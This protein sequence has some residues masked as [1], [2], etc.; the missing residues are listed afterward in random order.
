MIKAWGHDEL[1]KDLAAHLKIPQRMVWTDMQLGPSGSV[2]PDVYVITKSYVRPHPTAYECKISREDFRAD[3][4]AGKWQAYLQ[5]AHAVIFA[6]P[7]GL[8]EKRE[9]PELCGLIVRYEKSWRAVRAATINPRPIPEEAW[10][11]LLIDGIAREGPMIRARHWQEFQASKRFSEKFGHVA[12]RY[13]EDLVEAERHAQDLAEERERIRHQAED[14]AKEIVSRALDQLPELWKEILE[15]VG[16]PRDS[17]SWKV[18]NAIAALREGR[19]GTAAA[20]L[21]DILS[22]LRRLLE[23]PEND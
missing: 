21:K 4:T 3:L 9:L 13:C 7:A 16:L 11:K 23:M 15:I 2:R 6:V 8:I 17:A 10:L 22:T 1:V 20:A 19:D 12:A 5:Y 14:E 18:R